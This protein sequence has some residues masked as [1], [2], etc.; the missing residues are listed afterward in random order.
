[1]DA[2][3]QQLER[4]EELVKKYPLKLP[5]RAVADFLGMNE[6]GLKAALMRGNAPFGFAYQKT[7]GAYRVIVIPTVKFYL[8]Y[9]NCNAQM[10]LMPEIIMKERTRQ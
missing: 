9:T 5:L 3:K 6:E 2:I 7:D 4:L 8:W 1:M 10:I